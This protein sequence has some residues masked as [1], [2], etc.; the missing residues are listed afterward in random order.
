MRQWTVY[1]AASGKLVAADERGTPLKVF[2][3]LHA[4][5]TWAATQR[6]QGNIV[7]GNIV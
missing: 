6:K 1:R 3:S 5:L 4:A 2:E 7:H